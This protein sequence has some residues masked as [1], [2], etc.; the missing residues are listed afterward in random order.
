[1]AVGS[2]VAFGFC[3]VF[4]RK[5]KNVDY[6]II[7][8]YNSIIGVSLTSLIVLIDRAAVSEEFRFYTSWQY[9]MLIAAASCGLLNVNFVT[10]AG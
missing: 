8:F 1:M 3:Q 9:G 2:G 7:M 5:L 10:L 4:N 6:T